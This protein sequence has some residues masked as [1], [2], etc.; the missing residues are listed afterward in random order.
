MNYPLE[1][2]VEKDP[3]YGRIGIFQGG[4]TKMFGRWRSEMISCMIDNRYYFSTW[5]RMLIVKR[6]MSL[7]GSEFNASSFWE[8]DVTTDPV[9]DVQSSK[10]MGGIELPHREMPLLPPPVLHEVE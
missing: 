10:V 4:G 8:K 5:Q 6:I 3:N 2:L 1:T 7:S 9:R